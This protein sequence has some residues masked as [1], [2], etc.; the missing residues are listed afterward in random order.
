MPTNQSRTDPPDVNAA[1]DLASH[2]ISVVNYWLGPRPQPRH[3]T[4]ADAEE[5]AIPL[6]ASSRQR[7]GPTLATWRV[8]YRVMTL[9]SR[10]N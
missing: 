5:R 6:P 8:K 4:K 9:G 10:A 3:A 7:A 2:D 1:W